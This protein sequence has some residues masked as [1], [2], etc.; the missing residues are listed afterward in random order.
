MFAPLTEYLHKM[1]LSVMLVVSWKVQGCGHLDC[2]PCAGENAFHI[3]LVI[4]KNG[5]GKR[6]PAVLGVCAYLVFFCFF[7]AGNK[8]LFMNTLLAPNPCLTNKTCGF[9]F[10]RSW[11]LQRCAQRIPLSI[12]L[13][14]AF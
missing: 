8:L 2:L 9:S 4:H 5:Q 7:F 13:E 11:R 1:A 3:Y 14:A 10:R 6:N 12:A